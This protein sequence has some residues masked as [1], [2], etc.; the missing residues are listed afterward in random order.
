MYILREGVEAL[1]ICIQYLEASMICNQY[2]QRKQDPKN[3]FKQLTTLHLTFFL[4]VSNTTCVWILPQE[5][6][7]QFAA[8]FNLDDYKGNPL[9]FFINGW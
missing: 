7:A 4:P 1:T 5:Q 2:W 8:V 9:N 6:N 3:Y